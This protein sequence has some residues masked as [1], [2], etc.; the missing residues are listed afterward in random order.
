MVVTSFGLAPLESPNRLL[1]G[2]GSSLWPQDRG[3]LLCSGTQS[4]LV[5]SAMSPT[6]ACHATTIPVSEEPDGASS[7][8]S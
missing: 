1:T 6:G 8:R 2:A 4:R 5:W 3:K 7:E